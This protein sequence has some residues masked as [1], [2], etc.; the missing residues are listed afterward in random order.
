MVLLSCGSRR[1]TLARQPCAQV[2]RRWRVNSIRVNSPSSER[3]GHRG[4]AGQRPALNRRG[5]SGAA[6]TS[7]PP[8]SR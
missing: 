4:N 8:A 7:G 5:E 6:G 3:Y 1:V 2:D